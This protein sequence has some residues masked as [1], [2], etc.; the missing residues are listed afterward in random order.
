MSKQQLGEELFRFLEGKPQQSAERQRIEA[1]RIASQSAQAKNPPTDLWQ[2]IQGRIADEH[3]TEST[4][5]SFFRLLAR[6]QVAVF[7]V[8]VVGILVGAFVLMNTATAPRTTPLVELTSLRPQKVGD[9]VVARGLKIQATAPGEISRE[10]G[11]VEKITLRSGEFS[12]VLQHAELERSTRFIFPGGS[13]EPLGTAFTVKI[14][15]QGT[16]VNLT[17]GKIRVVRYQSD[18]QKWQTSEVMAPYSG[19]FET[20][21][22]EKVPE[23]VLPDEITKPVLPQKPVS[24]Y[25]RYVGRDITLELKNGD[26]LTGRVRR[27]AAGKILLSTASGELNV[28]EAQILRVQKN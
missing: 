15:G 11:S 6:P 9:T 25:S 8:L 5:A 20:Q 23:S 27:A 21:P 17:E 4:L 18:M 22:V 14:G 10:P 28:P 13:L 26:R 12:V 1:L 7:A 2:K 24:A 19:M 16:V 3:L